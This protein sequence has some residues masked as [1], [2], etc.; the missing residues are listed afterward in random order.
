MEFATDFSP[1]AEEG[2]IERPRG[3]LG[4]WRQLSQLPPIG[5]GFVRV[6]LNENGEPMGGGQNLSAGE[7]YWV[8]AVSWVKVDIRDHTMRY[9]FPL[10]EPSGNA[11]FDVT[12]TLTVTVKNPMEV[13]RRG[14]RS[15]RGI[16]EPALQTALLHIAGQLGRP[17]VL[18]DDPLLALNECRSRVAVAVS[19]ALGSYQHLTL[20]LSIG[21]VMGPVAVSFDRATQNHHDDLL[22]RIQKGR[23]IDV[24]AS[25]TERET[26]HA[27]ANREAW[28]KALEPY[29]SDPEKRAFEIVAA[30]PSEENI[31][32]VVAHLDEDDK[33][34]RSEVLAVLNTLVDRH[35][36]D[37]DDE[38]YNVTIRAIIDGLGRQKANDTPLG[39]KKIKSLSVATADTPPSPAKEGDA[40]WNDD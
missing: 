10:S 26:T 28:R 29:L 18:G 5:N 13:V 9:T 16:V 23:I 7:K 31:R 37:K 21:A 35:Y 17:Y 40:D 24:D 36:L 32:A 19:S 11:S 33:G 3:M 39:S 27:I 14:I 34:R 8:S 38:L 25:N 22:N 6:L 30:N 20:P 4:R 15:A 12:V 1:V 2:T